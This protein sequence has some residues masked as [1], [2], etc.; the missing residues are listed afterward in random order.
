VYGYRS[1]AEAAEAAAATPAAA[2]AGSCAMQLELL[3]SGETLQ[4]VL[5]FWNQQESV[6]K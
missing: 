4:Q 2:A 6:Q 1:T 5:Q 3:R